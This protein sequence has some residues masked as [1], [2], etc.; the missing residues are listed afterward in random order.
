MN[1]LERSG[2]L[3]PF[4]VKSSAL[5]TIFDCANVAEDIDFGVLLS[6]GRGMGAMAPFG[7]GADVP[8]CLR[9]DGLGRSRFFGLTNGSAAFGRRILKKGPFELVGGVH[10]GGGLGGVEL[11]AEARDACS[12]RVVQVRAPKSRKMSRGQRVPIC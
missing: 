8:V 9:V 2:P 4:T 12:R 1:V 3:N 10:P 11:I 7:A 6:C 5:G